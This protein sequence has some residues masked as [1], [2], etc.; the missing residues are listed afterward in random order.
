MKIVE[1]AYLTTNTNT[2]G[3]TICRDSYDQEDQDQ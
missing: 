2:H 1:T 3:R